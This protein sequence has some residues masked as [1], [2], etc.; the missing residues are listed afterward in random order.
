M[1]ETY[2]SEYITEYNLPLNP[3][4]AFLT[5]AWRNI[6]RPLTPD[7]AM[8]G[9]PRKMYTDIVALLDA[10]ERGLLSADDL[11]VESI[12]QLLILR[13]EHR[14]ELASL[15][16]AGASVG[17]D[18][19]LSSEEIV[20]LVEQHLSTPGTSRLPVLIVAAAYQAAASIIGEQVRPLQAHN[21]ADLQTGALGDLEITLVNEDAVV[22]VYEMK[23][24]EV[25]KED[26]LLAQRKLRQVAKRP[27]NY[28]FITTKPVAKE[29]ADFA[30]ELYRAT[31]TEYAILD[32]TGFLRHF[33]HF[34]HRVRGVYLQEYEALLLSEPDSAVGHAVK[35]HFLT[36]RR[37]YE[38]YSADADEGSIPPE[39]P[40]S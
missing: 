26:I 15:R 27:D 25:A 37:T 40:V 39:A 23:L 13:E 20:S 5:P 2:I 29:V 3:T 18:I 34:F 28:I 32:C 7:V 35:M 24:K 11:L 38:A 14:A 30:Y 9:R 33:L 31:G 12:R 19:P 22:T 36:L 1:D 10:V 17:S 21:A 8:V 16:Q 4:T 6:D